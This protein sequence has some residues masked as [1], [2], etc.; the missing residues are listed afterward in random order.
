MAKERR[1][2]ADYLV[3]LAVRAAVC[4]IQALSPRQARAAARLLARVA[5]RLDRRHRDVAKENLRHA[6]PGRYSGPELDRVV[7]RVYEHFL[8]LVTEIAHLPRKLHVANWRN[9]IDL[10]G[11]G[12]T[13]DALT[14]GRP[15]LIVTG[16]FGNWEM[17]GFALGLLGFKTFAVARVLDNP[18]L[19]RFLKEFRQKT[20]QR[21]LAKKGD[22][23]QMQE[24]LAGGAV[25]ATLADQ[26]A[27]PR[28]LFAGHC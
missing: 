14:A 1:P 17:A 6:F 19:E 2:A 25:I 4:V 11:S 7:L 3:Y 21:I 8:G 24:L 28:G 5:F 27:G 12:A 13:V 9:Y 22:F 15:L 26:D 20:G 23:D 18:H 16:H 10:G